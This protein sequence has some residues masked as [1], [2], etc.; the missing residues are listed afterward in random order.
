MLEIFKGLEKQETL[1][2]D[3][4]SLGLEWADKVN[5]VSRTA[6]SIPILIKNFHE[7]ILSNESILERIKETPGFIE[8][9]QGISEM[10]MLDYLMNKGHKDLTL[11]ST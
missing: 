2:L 1:S 9:D 7:N 8:S 11:D 10:N 6:F 3:T 4:V 5:I